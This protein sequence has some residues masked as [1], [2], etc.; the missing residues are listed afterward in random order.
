[1]K[2]IAGVRILIGLWTKLTVIDENSKVRCLRI[3]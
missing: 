2:P 1:M 3:V